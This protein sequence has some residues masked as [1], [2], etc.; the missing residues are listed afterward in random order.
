MSAFDTKLIFVES[1]LLILIDLLKLASSKYT[2]LPAEPLKEEGIVLKHRCRG[3]E[4]HKKMT[5]P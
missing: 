5:S 4:E 2:I 3:P 1:F